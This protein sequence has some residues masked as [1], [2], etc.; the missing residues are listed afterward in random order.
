LQFLVPPINEQQ[1]IA[2]YL[3]HKTTLIDTLIE[4]KKRRIDL[5]K[6]E[7]TA[8]INQAVTK[9][10]D[11]N[12]QFKDSGIEW[13]GEIP[14]HWE[15][16]RL[17]YIAEIVLGKM[18]TPKDKGDYQ[19]RPY[20]RAKNLLWFKVDANDIKEM[21]FSDKERIQ[22]L[23]Q[24]EDLLVSEGGE[25]GRTCIWNN[26]LPECYIQ[27]SVNRV[28]FY[29]DHFSRYFLFLFSI[30]GYKGHF[31]AVVSKVSIAHLTKEKLIDI[32]FIIPPI[33]EQKNIVEYTEKETTRIDTL[34][35]KTQ[36]Q[37]DLL[38]EYRTALISEV[39]TGKIDVRDWEEAE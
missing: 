24:K 32:S 11:P 25:V 9:G 17:K 14:V 35:T 36:N 26:E 38:Q 8:V 37:I 19:L 31:D 23:L 34:I 28:R 13:L 4:K 5:L 30:F 15:V 2:A 1:K 29:Y 16:K 12:V 27:N 39:V 33:N 3:D 20:L 21:W 18:L 7:R 10:L 22:Y 6:E